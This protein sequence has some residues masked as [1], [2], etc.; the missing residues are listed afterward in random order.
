MQLRQLIDLVESKQGANRITENAFLYLA[1]KP[2]KNK[3]AQCSTCQVWLP[4]SKR[5]GFFG[6]DDHVIG[7]ASCG[8]YVHGEPHEDQAITGAVTP[9]QAG[10]VEGQVRCENCTWYDDGICNL[11]KLL[12]RKMPDAF[13]LKPEVEAQA[14]CNAWQS[15]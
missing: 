4:K 13:D 7:N 3:H 8:L 6:P 14:C 9:Q 12:M 11:F 15:K 1:P 2:P 5:C 10:Y